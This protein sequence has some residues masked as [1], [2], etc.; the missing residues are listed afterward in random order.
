M[1]KAIKDTNVVLNTA[2]SP[3]I[4]LIPSNLNIL[5]KMI[6]G[7]NNVLKLATSSMK[8]GE[9]DDVNYSKPSE[10]PTSTSRGSTST[11][12]GSTSTSRGNTE[13]S[14]VSKEP[15]MDESELILL[16]TTLVSGSIISKFLIYTRF[17]Q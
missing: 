11:S 16:V 2:I 12:S 8:F 10:E 1:R 17:L 5:D 9:N 6:A 14:P 15:K 13:P 3:G 7:Y 4:I